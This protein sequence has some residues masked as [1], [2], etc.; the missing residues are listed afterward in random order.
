MEM[1]LPVGNTSFQRC[2]RFCCSWGQRKSSYD[3]EGNLKGIIKSIIFIGGITP[4]WENPSL[5]FYKILFIL[6]LIGSLLF[7]G[8]YVA[9][10]NYNSKLLNSVPTATTDAQ[11]KLNQTNNKDCV[12]KSYS[13]LKS[14]FIIIGSAILLI[15]CKINILRILAF[16]YLFLNCVSYASDKEWSK[17]LIIHALLWVALVGFLFI[18]FLTVINLIFK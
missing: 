17:Y 10:Q 1:G 16:Y 5:L 2:D 12:E 3:K 9:I 18:H 6:T 7:I 4:L 15:N 14:F 8:S 11:E 13:Y